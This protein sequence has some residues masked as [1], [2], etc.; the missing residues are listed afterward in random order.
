LILDSYT[1]RQTCK[2]TIV[3]ATAMQIAAADA[4]RE[5]F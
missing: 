3:I 1:D 5:I 4:L 2:Q